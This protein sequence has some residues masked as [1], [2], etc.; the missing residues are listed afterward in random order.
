MSKALGSGDRRSE[1]VQ[2]GGQAPGRFVRGNPGPRPELRR[3][4]RVSLD[5]TSP[6]E[7]DPVET[8]TRDHGVETQVGKSNTLPVQGHLGRGARDCGAAATG[9]RSCTPRRGSPLGGIE[10]GWLLADRVPRGQLV[11]GKHLRTKGP[12]LGGGGQML[13][14]FQHFLSQAHT[15]LGTEA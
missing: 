2:A 4:A 10:G 11:L 9:W 7:S 5:P 1:E 8:K 13:T 12:P 3:R 14:L 15:G 6:T